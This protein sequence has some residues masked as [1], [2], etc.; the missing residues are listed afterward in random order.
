[1]D[2]LQGRSN[3]Q[4]IQMILQILPKG[5]TLQ[6]QKSIQ[7]QSTR[8][9]QKFWEEAVASKPRSRTKSTAP[10][11]SRSPSLERFANA[12]RTTIKNNNQVRQ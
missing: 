3:D 10:S 8:S 4:M 5:Y 7:P 12:A 11:D 9:K 1:M 6:M 2:K